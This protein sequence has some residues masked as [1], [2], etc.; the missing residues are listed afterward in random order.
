MTID[1]LVQELAVLRKQLA[2]AEIVIKEA[3][4]ALGATEEHAA[5]DRAYKTAYVIKE[6]IDTSEARL[7]DAAVAMYD[8]TEDKH[9]HQAVSIA[10]TKTPRYDREKVLAWCKE[11]ARI[12]VRE[13]LDKKPFNKAAR[14][15]II[16]P[17]LVTIEE[18]PT[19]RISRDLSEYVS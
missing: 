11:N 18:I 5:L 7:R 1:K 17:E 12:F 8:D 14:Q 15:G 2:D 16:A 4:A 19:V 10:V 3:Q 13:S 9:P 6:R